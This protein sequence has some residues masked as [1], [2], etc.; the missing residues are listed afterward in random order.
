MVFI[1]FHYCSV[2]I[3]QDGAVIT[4]SSGATIALLPHIYQ[5]DY[6]HLDERFWLEGSWKYLE[7]G[8]IETLHTINGPETPRQNEGSAGFPESR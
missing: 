8:D 3:Q 6:L 5:A 2:I 1:Q 4:T 7:T